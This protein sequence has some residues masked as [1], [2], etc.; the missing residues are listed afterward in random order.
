MSKNIRVI[1]F[2]ILFPVGLYAHVVPA[3]GAILNYRLAGFKIPERKDAA[4]YV[5]HIARNRVTD[6]SA[7][8]NE[9][10]THT[11]SS[12]NNCIVLLPS[13]GTAY[14][15]MVTCYDKN[16]KEIYQSPIYSFNTGSIS[17]IDTTQNG[18]LVMAKAQHHKDLLLMVDH[19]LVIY[20]L[21][22][23]PLWYMPQTHEIENRDVGI[24]DFKATADGT[25]TFIT[26]KD[27]F[28][29]NYNGEVIWKAPN[30]G[31]VSGA[32]TEWYHHEFTKLSNGH[33]M[34]AGTE[35]IERRIPGKPSDYFNDNDTTVRK[36]NDGNYYKQIICGT[37]I[38]Y[39][40][41]GKV[42]W[43]WRVSEHLDDKDFFW[44]KNVLAEPHN[45]NTHMN[46]F[47]FDEQHKLIYISFKKINQVIT[48]AYPSGKIVDRIGETGAPAKEA[49]PFYGQ[50][51]CKMDKRT[52]DLYVFNNNH[53]DIEP[54]YKWQ[55]DAEG[56]IT[57]HVLVYRHTPQQGGAL[58]KVWDFPC[59]FFNDKTLPQTTLRGGNVN[60]L[61]DGC[62]LINM[63]TTNA[64]A[65]VSKN[66][67][68]VWGAMP[69][70]TDA[71]NQKQNM[72]PYRCSYL[73]TKDLAKFIF[74]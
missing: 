15:W 40:A 22:G 62:L 56:Y 2:I 28:E 44:P 11:T 66:K 26:D 55:Y 13:F 12:T 16:G 69:Y 30:D 20:D 74:R 9:A 43:S 42:V 72:E 45:G 38:E 23:K 27:A 71:N 18:L 70:I 58:K 7:L 10:F 6:E 3:E 21:N 53:S 48:I 68:M 1:L 25:F 37:L 61:D 59:K 60:V 4:K 51:A 64:M 32:K 31:K 57:S 29:V 73:N 54:V 34:I 39:D 41:A 67:Q 49:S 65:I 46:S 35:T 14:C 24:R 17:Y 8:K 63:G 47:D 5:F 50:H 33:Y 19:M 52:G 36:G